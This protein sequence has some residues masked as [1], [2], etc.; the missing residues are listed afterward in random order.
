MYLWTEDASIKGWN[1]IATDKNKYEGFL[2]WFTGPLIIGGYKLPIIRYNDGGGFFRGYEDSLVGW[3]GDRY[4]FSLVGS[5]WLPARSSCG[6]H[7]S[8]SRSL[9]GHHTEIYFL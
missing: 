8:W 2:R 5:I 9:C 7:T 6:G 4:S 1:N 3:I